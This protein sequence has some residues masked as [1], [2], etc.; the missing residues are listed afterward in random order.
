MIS[1]RRLETQK[2][3]F[4]LGRK[5][6]P[7]SVLTSQNFDYKNQTSLSSLRKK[8]S[9]YFHKR[10]AQEQI[11][12]DSKLPCSL[13]CLENAGE[14]MVEGVSKLQEEVHHAKRIPQDE[15]R[16]VNQGF[17]NKIEEK[18]QRRMNNINS[19][20]G[21]KTQVTFDFNPRYEVIK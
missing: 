12:I 4:G 21:N 3:F 14:M 13:D 9:Q 10:I 8:Q 20:G 6:Q 2:S 15:R 7:L 19:K 1:D 16:L 18:E 5:I 11:N 17:L